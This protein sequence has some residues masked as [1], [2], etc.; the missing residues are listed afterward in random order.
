[1]RS[2]PR[3]SVQRAGDVIQYAIDNGGR[4]PHLKSYSSNLYW[5][6]YHCID[7]I[8]FIFAVCCF[9]SV[10]VYKLVKGLFAFACGG[11]KREKTD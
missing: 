6:Q 7:V 1:M 11:R 4:L 3:T 2:L 8:F 5:F 9:V 10:L